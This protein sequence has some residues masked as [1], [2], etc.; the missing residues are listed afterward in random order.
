MD[1]EFPDIYPYLTPRTQKIVDIVG[2]LC[3]PISILCFFLLIDLRGIVNEYI[4]FTLAVVCVMFFFV[5]LANVLYYLDK[6]LY[7]KEA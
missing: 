4:L 6:K 7:F 2:I 3:L 1:N 5:G